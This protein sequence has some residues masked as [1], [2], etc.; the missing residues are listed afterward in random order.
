MADI[1]LRIGVTKNIKGWNEETKVF[2]M[3]ILD[4]NSQP[5]ALTGSNVTFKT[6]Q[7][8]TVTTYEGLVVVSPEDSTALR[9]TLTSLPLM[10]QANYEVKITRTDNTVIIIEGSLNIVDKV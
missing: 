2:D 8:R 9:W 10:T 4:V 6:K 1:N 7:G 3:P 5:V